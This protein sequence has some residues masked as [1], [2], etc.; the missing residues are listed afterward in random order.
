M[1]PVETD[2]QRTLRR[3]V[4]GYFASF[5]TQEIRAEL[6]RGGE[7][8]QVYLELIRKMGADGWLGVSIPKEY[9]GRGLSTMEQYIFFNELR[10]AAAPANM[11]TINTVAPAIASMAT[12][13]QK[14]KYLP[15]ILAGQLMVSIG[16]TEPDAGTDLASLQTRA[17]RDGD[18][19]V[20]TGQKTYTSRAPVADYIWLACITDR[21]APRH[22]GISIIM[23]PTDSPGYSWTPMP[24]I[25]LSTTATYYDHVRVPVGNLVGKENEGWSLITS[26]LNHERVAIAAQSGLAERLWNEVYRW[27]REKSSTTGRRPIDEPWVRGELARTYARLEATRLLN[28]QMAAKL[29]ARQ[30]GPADPSVSKVNGTESMQD[31]Y[32]SLLAIVGPSSFLPEGSPEAFLAGELEFVARES[33]MYTFGGG[34]NEIQREMIAWR[35]LGV[36]RDTGGVR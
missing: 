4:R 15:G 13:E 1:I 7:E 27:T 26:Q 16:Y 14:Q 9:G 11:V 28:Q 18:E 17:V 23:V 33:Q 5:M 35:G 6:I 24:T 20:I 19:F 10:R 3:E 2:E 22:K 34:V 32:R 8:S 25:G 21:D 31:I 36:V 29:A 30:L 12:P